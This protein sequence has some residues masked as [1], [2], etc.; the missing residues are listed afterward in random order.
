MQLILNKLSEIEMTAQ[1]IME[2]ALSQKTNLSEET[3]HA[4]MDFDAAQEKETTRRLQEIR[5]QLNED[6]ERQLQALRQSTDNHIA[7]MKTYYEKNHRQLSQEI[8]RQILT[9]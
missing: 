3:E 8:C 9:Q 2:D 4:C 1:E 7:S 5:R 6:K